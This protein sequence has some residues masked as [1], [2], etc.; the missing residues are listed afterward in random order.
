MFAPTEVLSM[1]RPLA[2]LLS[3]LFS[4]VAVMVAADTARAADAA[5]G[6]KL[7]KRWCASC[8][9]VA[10]DQARGSTAAPPFSEIAKQPGFDAGK[11]ALFLLAPHPRMPDMNLS[12]AEA[13][14]LAAYIA[15]RGK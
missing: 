2:G 1:P 7:A 15:G 3:V 14:D 10:A 12:R 13:A 4:C 6:E 9:V 8:H 11:L 5:N